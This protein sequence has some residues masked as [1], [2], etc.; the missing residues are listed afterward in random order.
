MKFLKTAFSLVLLSMSLASFAGNQFLADRHIT[1]SMNCES[2]HLKGM[3]K[4]TPSSEQCF[5]CHGNYEQLRKKTASPKKM[6]P[7][8]THL[9]KLEC[10]GCHRAH[11]APVPM[12]VECHGEEMAKELN[13]K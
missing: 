12:C 1:K 10:S 2:C 8:D 11:S 4:K 6:N 5:A 3:S 9:G 13:L 7:H